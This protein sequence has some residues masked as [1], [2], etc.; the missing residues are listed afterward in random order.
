MTLELHAVAQYS[1]LRIVDSLA[2]GAVIGLFAAAL[3]RIFRR[4]NAG[5]RFAIWFSALIAIAVVPLVGGS[6]AAHFASSRAISRPVL[7]LSDSWAVYLFAAWGLIAGWFLLGVLRGLRH[8]HSLHKSCVPVDASTLDPILQDTLRRARVNREVTVCTSELVRV[9][10]AV[11]LISPAIIFPNWALQ[12]LS[13]AE[14][15]Q[16]FLHE[17]AHLRRRDD[18]TNLAQQLVRALLFFHPAVW[19]IENK[20]ALEREMACDDAVLAETGSPRAYAE[21]LAHLAER[22]FVQRTLALAQAAIGRVRQTSTRVAEILDVNRPRGNTRSWKPVSLVAG[23]ALV[24]AVGIARSPKLIAFDAA[25]YI[26]QTNSVPADITPAQDFPQFVPATRAK[27]N[28]EPVHRTP[29]R[30]RPAATHS[31]MSKPKPNRMLH[32]TSVQQ[33]PVTETVFLLIQSADHSS[34]A[35]QIFQIQM[36]R[37]TLLRYVAPPVSTQTPTKKT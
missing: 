33:A 36:W 6:V 29:T 17:L 7:I 1:A 3:L 13:P 11:G 23:F 18:W 24:C 21:T 15:N 2:G 20:A 8:L 28:L 31:A 10:T 14:L 4:Q 9:P 35:P 25:P 37:V 5:I 12:E 22:S 34:S 32:L 19:W 30:V 16:I 26:A 27:L